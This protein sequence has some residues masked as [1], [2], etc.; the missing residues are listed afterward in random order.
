MH[1]FYVVPRAVNA[2]KG[3]ALG[4][5]VDVGGHVGLQVGGC[6]DDVA[7]ANHPAHTPTGH[8]VGLCHAVEN[9]AQVSELGYCLQDGDCLNTV[10]GK[11]LVNLIG[12]HENPLGRCPFA[13]GAGFLFGVDGA[14]R[15][16]GETKMSAL[17]AG[18]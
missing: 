17:V 14:G 11:M 2:A 4:D 16:G 6:S 5:V 1:N 3:C 15:V 18:V 9:D 7:R 10:I 8:G 13:D 12:Q